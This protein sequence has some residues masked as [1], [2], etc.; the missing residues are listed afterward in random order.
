MCVGVELLRCSEDLRIVDRPQDVLMTVRASSEGAR[1]EL[2]KKSSGHELKT[3]NE[4]VSV[5][6][7]LVVVLAHGVE[8]MLS[9]KLFTCAKDVFKLLVE[10]I[11]SFSPGG[12]NLLTSNS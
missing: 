5:A 7:S 2:K 8:G 3:K 10:V 4:S 11:T 6:T 1:H 9:W 12:P